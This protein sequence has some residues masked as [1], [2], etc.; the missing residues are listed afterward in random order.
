MIRVPQEIG[1]LS[2]RRD[3]WSHHFRATNYVQFGLSHNHSW[4]CDPILDG[5]VLRISFPGLGVDLHC[6]IK[7]GTVAFSPLWSNLIQALKHV[8]RGIFIDQHDGFHFMM[9]CH[10]P[11][12]KAC[13]QKANHG[14]HSHTPVCTAKGKMRCNCSHTLH[15]PFLKILNQ[16][17]HTSDVIH[18]V[19]LQL[20]RTC[21]CF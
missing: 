2:G 8:A 15:P 6:C 20:E 19:Q 7:K 10:C 1:Y 17:L 21:Q 11:G 3:R 5:E 14:Q 12:N 13:N 9:D 16:T 18:L 4:Q